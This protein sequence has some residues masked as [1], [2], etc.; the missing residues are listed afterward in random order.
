MSNDLNRQS[1]SLSDVTRVFQAMP[2][3]FKPGVAPRNL[4]YY[5]SIDE[6]S[7]TVFVG[8]E[9]CDVKEGKAV[10]DADCFLKTSS[11]IFLGTIKGE[12]TPS[13]M[14]I[15]SGRIKTNNPALL[16]TFRDVFG[17]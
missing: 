17:D 3:R 16:Q 11:E 12:Y 8:P 13:F 15:M 1:E 4:S 5:F 7:W 9:A 6:E 10:E 14:D 2:S